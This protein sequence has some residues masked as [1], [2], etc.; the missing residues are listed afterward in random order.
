MNLIKKSTFILKN[1]GIKAFIK[2]AIKFPINRLNLL[3]QRKA[4]EKARKNSKKATNF[5][6]SF[7]FDDVFINQRVEMIYNLN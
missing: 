6:K 5:L 1:Y 4:K 2:K 3:R 7:L